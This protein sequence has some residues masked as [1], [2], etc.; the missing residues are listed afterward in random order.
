ME[1]EKA[2]Y[3]FI[4]YAIYF[5]INIGIRKFGRYYKS[6]DEAGRNR[7]AFKRT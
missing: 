7:K 3:K 5:L 1:F 6:S 4:D 2:L